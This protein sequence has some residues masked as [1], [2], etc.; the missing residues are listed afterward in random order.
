MTVDNL[1]SK[2]LKIQAVYLQALEETGAAYAVRVI[3]IP[4]ANQDTLIFARAYYVY[5]T[6]EGEQ[7]TV[8]GDIYEAN[9]AGKI[10]V[11]DGVL[12]W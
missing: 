9:Y 6:A 1:S 3:N 8:Y 7:I 11:N 12:E 2:T 10:E 4:E 5:E